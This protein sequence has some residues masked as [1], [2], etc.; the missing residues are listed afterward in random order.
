MASMSRSYQSLMVCGEGRRR[1]TARSACTAGGVAARSSSS[2]SGAGVGKATKANGAAAAAAA[3]AGGTH[4]GVASQQRPAHQHAQRRL[5]AVLCGPLKVAAGGGAAQHACGAG[6]S[7]GGLHACVTTRCFYQE[8]CLPQQY[9][10]Q[11][12]QLCVNLSY[13][14]Q[15]QQMRPN[16]AVQQ[17][18]ID[19]SSGSSSTAGTALQQ[20]WHPP[21]MRGI[22]VTGF[23][24][25][26][27]IFQMLV[28]AEAPFMPSSCSRRNTW[29]GEVGGGETGQAASLGLHR[30]WL[31]VHIHS[32][33]LALDQRCG[34]Q[35]ATQ[36]H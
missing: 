30:P 4:L 22:Q 1:G 5:E 14:C 34:V 24:S 19:T 18:V 8:T 2:S 12:V 31:A 28:S 33:W 6:R 35:R 26:R 32:R 29:E 27:R 7:A 21:Q 36:H 9:P 3:S 11:D 25:C 20:L 17:F 15:L 23:I 16:L 10:P 13:A